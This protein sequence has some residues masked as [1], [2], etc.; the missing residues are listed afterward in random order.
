VPALITALVI[1]ACSGDSGSSAPTA[2]APPAAT[3]TSVPRTG[4]SATVAPRSGPPGIEVTVSG[5][6]WPAGADVTISADVPGETTPYA[7]ATAG[8][9]GSF[10]VRF[11]LEEL[12]GGGRLTVGVLN[13]KIAAGDASVRLPYSVL[14]PRPIFPTSTSG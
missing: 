9:D 12:P 8:A 7:T 14:T 10:L 6:G 11:L 4:P 3:A 2:I 13:L 1:A 5:T